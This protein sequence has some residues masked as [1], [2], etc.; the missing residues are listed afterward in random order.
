MTAAIKSTSKGKAT[1]LDNIPAEWFGNLALSCINFLKCA[2][3]P[4]SQETA[5]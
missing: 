4:S 2:T 1:G 3:K 5:R